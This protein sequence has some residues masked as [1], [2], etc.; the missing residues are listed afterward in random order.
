M[1]ILL[2][3]KRYYTIILYTQITYH[4]DFRI[5][6]DYFKIRHLINGNVVVNITKQFYI[7]KYIPALSGRSRTIKQSYT[8]RTDEVD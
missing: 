1:T 2:L 4:H 5:H 6:F 7:K 8:I 3:Y